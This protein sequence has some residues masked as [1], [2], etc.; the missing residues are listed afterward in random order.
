MANK[1]LG[2]SL[3]GVLR[4]IHSQFDIIYRKFFINNDSLVK[5]D[6]NFSY[7][8]SEQTDTNEERIK[9]L[10]TAKINLPVTTYDLMNHYHF[11]SKEDFDNFFQTYAFEVFGMASQ[12]PRAFD[13][14]NRLQA[15]GKG[16]DLFDTVLLVKGKDKIAQSTY[17]FL[18]KSGCKIENVRHVDTDAEKWNYCDVLIDDSPE[19]FENKPDGKISIKISKEYNAYSTADYSFD[20]ISAVFGEL[21]LIKVFHPEKYEEI[22]SK[23]EKKD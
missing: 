18:G 2:I 14:A 19:S 23:Q 16:T 4:D 3:D 21:F 22:K 17:H 1:T 5:A 11:D 20:N 13:S 15:F 8:V 7:L 10:I 12:F 6:D 9:E